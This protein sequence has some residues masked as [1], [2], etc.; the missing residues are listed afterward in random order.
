MTLD[1]CHFT[2]KKYFNPKRAGLFCLSHGRGRIRPPP[3]LD[4]GRGAVK[5]SEI[6]HARRVSQYERADEIS[7]PKIKA[8]LNLQIYVNYIHVFICLIITDKMR[9]FGAFK[10]F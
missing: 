2:A 1:P 6:W 9:P 4:L 3:P 8:F 10:L 7:I 5:N